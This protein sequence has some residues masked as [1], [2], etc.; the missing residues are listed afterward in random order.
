[1]ASKQSAENDARLQELH[2]QGLG[3]NAIA[4]ELDVSVGTITTWA[5]RLGLDFDRSATQVAVAARSV[6]LKERRQ[7]LQEQLLDLAER[8]IVRAQQP[9]LVSG[10]D[11][12]GVFVAREVPE[13]PARETKDF[14]QAA[15]AALASSLKL[16]QV[17]AGDAGRED[18]RG[19][20]R[21]LGE[22]MTTAAQE[23]G[24]DDASEYGA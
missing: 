5:R 9:Y 13:P 20:L 17:D 3:R 8:T 12:M 14:T 4:R 1:M 10:F 22:A 24:V 15:S 11:N 18:A 2:G 23:L 16:A 19:L 21:S 7:R 6:D